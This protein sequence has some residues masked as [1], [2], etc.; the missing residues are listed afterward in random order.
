[1]PDGG[2]GTLRDLPTKTRRDFAQELV[3]ALQGSKSMVAA[4][5]AP[6]HST[7]FA[8]I[9]AAMQYT[10]PEVVTKDQWIDGLAA[11]MHSSGVEWVPGR[12]RQRLTHRRIVRLTGSVL[13]TEVL[14]ARAGSSKRLA[15]EADFLQ[16]GPIRKRPRK[17]RIDFGCTIPFED[18]PPLIQAGF[19]RLKKLF[20]KSHDD[21]KILE[22]YQQAYNTLQD[23]LGTKMCDLMLMLVLTLSSSSVTPQ[24]A[25]KERC[26]SGAPKEKQKEQ[27][28]L[29]ANMVT[30]M[31]WFLQPNNFPWGAEDHGTILRISEMTKK[32]G[33][34]R[35]HRTV[36]LYD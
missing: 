11:A 33:K 10:R 31:L 27:S 4:A 5:F 18:V 30:R 34:S 13:S 1:M 23:I 35:N 29:A 16:D 19:K 28:L 6:A 9:K 26:F 21:H 22:H 25:P 3:E 17:Q 8:T 20:E 36:M 2:P 32:I 7:W 14:T 24:V 12:H 15:L